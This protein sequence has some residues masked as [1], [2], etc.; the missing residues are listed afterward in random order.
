MQSNHLNSEQQNVA[1]P[2]PMVNLFAQSIYA[3]LEAL[4]METN[5]SLELF[6]N[7]EYTQVKTFLQANI[8]QMQY[9]LNSLEILDRLEPTKA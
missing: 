1:I 7:Q 5:V 6:G 4:A 8:Q 9:M 3:Q 2:S